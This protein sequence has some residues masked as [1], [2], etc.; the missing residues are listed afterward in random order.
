MIGAAFTLTVS[1]WVQQVQFC[2]RMSSVRGNSC[3]CALCQTQQH[4]FAHSEAHR[5]LATGT[6]ES[7]VMEDTT[8]PCFCSVH[9]LSLTKQMRKKLMMT[10]ELNLC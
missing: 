4:S 8:V 5:L 9:T 6:T 1:L 10:R 7:H 3:P 2:Y